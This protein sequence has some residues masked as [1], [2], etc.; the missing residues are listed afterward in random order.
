MN[1]TKN[2]QDNRGVNFDPLAT[3]KQPEITLGTPAKQF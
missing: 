2:D 1:D 3:E